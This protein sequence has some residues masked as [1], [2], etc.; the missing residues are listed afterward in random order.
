MDGPLLDTD[1]GTGSPR[2]RYGDP[3]FW[4]VAIVAAIVFWVLGVYRLG[5]AFAVLQIAIAGCALPLLMLAALRP[6]SLWAVI[7]GYFVVAMFNC[8]WYAMGLGSR[9]LL[10]KLGGVER[11]RF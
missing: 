3:D 4:P 10:W 9:W 8:A 7:L 1:T 6:P 2:G 11:T 5:V